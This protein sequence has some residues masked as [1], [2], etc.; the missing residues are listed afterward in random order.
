MY[1][2]R[3]GRLPV[4][5]TLLLD[6]ALHNYCFSVQYFKNRLGECHL[7]TTLLNTNHDPFWLELSSIGTLVASSSRRCTKLWTQQSFIQAALQCLWEPTA[8]DHLLLPMLDVSWRDRKER[9]FTRR[10]NVWTAKR[11]QKLP[12]QTITVHCC[13]CCSPNSA[14][15]KEQCVIRHHALREPVQDNLSST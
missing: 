3:G 10:P 12:R 14:L 15:G 11:H 4:S 13:C 7:L 1:M 2:V 8:T 5:L 9:K 6:I